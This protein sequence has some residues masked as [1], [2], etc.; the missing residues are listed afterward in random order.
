MTEDPTE[1]QIKA[2]TVKKVTESVWTTVTSATVE[3]SEEKVW[4]VP[5]TVEKL[6]SG[7]DGKFIIKGIDEGTFLL[8]ETDAPAGYNKLTSAVKLVVDANTK[9][10][11]SG[12][13]GTD[14][15]DW[16]YGKETT[17]GELALVDLTLKVDEKQA[18]SSDDTNKGIVKTNIENSKG[19]TLPS[20]GGI[21][22]TLFY[23]GGGAMVAVAGVFLITKKRMGRR[24]D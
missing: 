7:K 12:E 3:G 15:Q 19:S 24:E 14:R 17:Q 13:I 16:Q 9:D 10:V 20:T 1:E 6:V 22:T 2:K 11:A 21:G 8:E 4:T 23:V 18:V 5:A